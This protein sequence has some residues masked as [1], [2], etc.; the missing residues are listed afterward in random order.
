M[1]INTLPETL[2]ARSAGMLPTYRFFL[3][4]NRAVVPKPTGEANR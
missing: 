2:T 4:P 3:G 1:A